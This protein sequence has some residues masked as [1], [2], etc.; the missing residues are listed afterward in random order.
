MRTLLS[1]APAFN[2]NPKIHISGCV[3]ALLPPPNT[4]HTIALILLLFLMFHNTINQISKDSKILSSLS[5]TE[6]DCSP[7]PPPNPFTSPWQ[8]HVVAHMSTNDHSPT[9]QKHTEWLSGRWPNQKTIHATTTTTAA[10]KS[11]SRKIFLLP[12]T[13]RANIEP[14]IIIIN[15]HLLRKP[16]YNLHHHHDPQRDRQWPPTCHLVR[17]S[18]RLLLPEESPSPLSI[19][20]SVNRST[21]YY[22]DAH[23]P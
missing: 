17:I 19:Y 15:C 21:N 2:N 11:V 6:K 8:L 9:W 4:S 20:L 3:K 1:P 22:S 12:L 5:N 10:T 14:Q 13:A 23:V 18:P 7:P 16:I